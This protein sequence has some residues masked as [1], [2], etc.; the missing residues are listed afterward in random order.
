V[1]IELGSGNLRKIKILLSALD[2]AEIS[3]D[4]FALDLD[5]SELERTLSM[6]PS[7]MFKHV[8][9]NGL[10]G[11][12]DDG[13]RWMQEDNEARRKPKCVLSLGSTIGSFARAD[14]ADFLGR[15]A[16]SVSKGGRSGAVLLAVDG[17]KDG[18]VVWRAYNDDEGINAEFIKNS[19]KHANRVLRYEAFRADEWTIK[20][21]WNQKNGSHD[22]YYIP[23][24]DVAIDG[25]N[26]KKDEKVKA[27]HSA[28]YDIHD[29]QRLYEKAG[30]EEV[31]AWI[32]HG[33]EY[34]EL[35]VFLHHQV[36]FQ[37]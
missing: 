28:K 32:L 11:S 10:W 17:C 33:K 12:Y 16:K 26:F 8:T 20:G 19:L 14:A 22:W 7:D 21:E 31:H 24:K 3:V 23:L 30:V 1:L 15:F 6:V 9:V 5:K 37:G 29:R 27:V 4:Y 36:P 35:L 2:R 13:Q 34:G 25:G 18:G